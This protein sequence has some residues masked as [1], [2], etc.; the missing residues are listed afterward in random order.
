[1][2]GENLVRF[3]EMSS[4]VKEMEQNQSEKR[5]NIEEKEETETHDSI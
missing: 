4:E 3:P 1:L 5:T 2:H